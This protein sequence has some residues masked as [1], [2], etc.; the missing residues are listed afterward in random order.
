MIK[1]IVCD[2]DGTIIGHDEKIPAAAP[3]FIQKAER[4][5]IMFTIATGRS[6]FFMKSKI[7]E[8]GI[9]LPYIATNG[10]TI[11]RG[12]EAILRLQFPIAPLRPVLQAAQKL[13]MSILYT[14]NG[15]ERTEYVNDW[16]GHE[17]AKRNITYKAEPFSEEEWQAIKADKILIMDSERNGNI[18]RIEEL[19]KNTASEATYVRYKNK[20]IELNEHTTN[21]AVALLNLIDILQ[22]P[23]EDVLVIGDDDND[24]EMFQAA[25]NSAAVGNASPRAREFAGYQC[26][27]NEFE[28][29]QEAICAFCDILR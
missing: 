18:F 24:I 10:A 19:I 8:L 9:T 5:G 25:C 2:M 20:A 11:M 14:I 17:G 13:N 28:G 22:V 3:A 7:R 12:D 26:K 27:A 16:V 23:I 29:V 15:I 4:K 21:K 6:E 1:L